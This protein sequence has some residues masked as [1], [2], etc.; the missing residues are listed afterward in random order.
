V[1]SQSIIY[2]VILLV[3]FYVLMFLPQRRQQKKKQTM[4]ASLNPGAKVLTSGGIYA[5]VISV[6][7]SVIVAKIAQDVEIELDSRAIIRVIE[8][9]VS[10]LS[11]NEVA[12][13]V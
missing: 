11:H 13:S 1:K 4:M 7:D 6:H 2:L 12:D 3:V 5:V 10:E 8:P 9:G